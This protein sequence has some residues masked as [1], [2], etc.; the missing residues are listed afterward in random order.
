MRRLLGMAFSFAR[1]V[2]EYFSFSAA[3]WR[4]YKKNNAENQPFFYLDI[5][6]R[7]HYLVSNFWP[8]FCPSQRADKK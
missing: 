7:I 8:L 2:R 1:W 4:K 6:T 5:M 3:A